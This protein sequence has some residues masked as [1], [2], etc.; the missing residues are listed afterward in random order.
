MPG[1]KRLLL[2]ALLLLPAWAADEPVTINDDG[3]WCWFEDER[4][5]VVDGKLIAGTIASGYRDAARKGAVEV[6]VWDLAGA[7]GSVHTLRRPQSEQERKL[8]LDD[9]NS[10]AFVLRPDGRI[11]AMYARHGNEAKIY[12]RISEQ[13]RDAGAWGEERVFV[14]SAASRVTYSNLHFLT[15]EKGGKGRDRKSVV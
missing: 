4:A 14:P 12:Y 10:P 8:W 1:M 7:K 11:L 2:A 3:G 13:P 9:H 5:I 6:A 15:R